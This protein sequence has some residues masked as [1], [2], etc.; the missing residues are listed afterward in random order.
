M[1]TFA[2]TGR[3]Y[4]WSYG[5]FV[6]LDHGNG[7]TSLYGHMAAVAVTEGQYVGKGQVIGYVGSTGRSSGNHC[8]F[9]IEKNHVLQDPADY[10][11]RP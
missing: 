6:K 7:Y 3:G 1:V 11:T 8:H 5:N 2:G 10:V 4:N 9:E